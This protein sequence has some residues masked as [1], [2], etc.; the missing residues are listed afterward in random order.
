NLMSTDYSSKD[1]KKAIAAELS[2]YRFA[3]PYGKEIQKFLRYGIGLHHAGLLPKYRL[4]VEKLAQKG[5]LKVIC[6]TD[7]LGVGVNVFIRIVVF[8]RLCKFDG[9]KTS[10]LS[11]RDFQQISGRA[12]RK[13]F[14]DL[15]T[16][17]V[18]APEHVIEN[19][20]L[21]AKAGDDPAKRRKIVK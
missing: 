9:E 4:L 17:V 15:G 14:D 11:V 3:S 12:G 5:L 13:G 7:T 20:K 2:G 21:E 6:G 16:V 18:Q 8:I 19:L 1:E 10:I